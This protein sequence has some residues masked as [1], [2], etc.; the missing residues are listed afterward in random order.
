MRFVF[1]IVWSLWNL[2]GTSAAA[3]P[4]CLLNFK[5]IRQF[6]VP[7]LWLRDFTRSYGKTSF[8]IL[9]RGSGRDSCAWPARCTAYCILNVWSLLHFDVF[10]FWNKMFL[11]LESCLAIMKSSAEWMMTKYSESHWYDDVM[12]KGRFTRYW[13]STRLIHHRWIYLQR[14]AWTKFEQ[15]VALLAIWGTMALRWRHYNECFFNEAIRKCFWWQWSSH[16]VCA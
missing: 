15:T 1:R 9:R 13:P 12:T 10:V 4:M 6:K 11:N 2:T 14:L 16:N 5:A 7:I 8:R 3:L